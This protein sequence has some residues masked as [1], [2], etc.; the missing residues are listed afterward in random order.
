M[1][2][3]LPW[4]AAGA[5]KAL[6]AGKL[7]SR[8]L[9]EDC[10]GRIAQHD[11]RLNSFVL[12]LEAS[13]RRAAQAA[14]RLRKAGRVRGSLHGIPF[15]LKDMFETAGVRTTAHSKLLI[16]HV[17]SRDSTVAAKLKAAG[18]ILLGKL[19]T[20]EFASGGP[21]WDLPFPPAR[22]PWNTARFTGGS[23]SGSGA[24]VA[25][26]LVP[27]AMGTDTSGSIRGPA[28][29][30]GI[31]GFKPTYGLVSRAG[32]IPMATTLDHCGPMAW[33][34]EDCALLL[35]CVAGH[36]P[37][38]PSSARTRTRRFSRAING[39]I[40]G[41]RIGVVRHMYERDIN[42][43]PQCADAIAQALK[44]LRGLG[45]KLVTV[46]LPPLADWDACCRLLLYPE[47]FAIHE[48]DLTERP[49]QYAAITRAR[50]MTGQGIRA[51]DYIQALRWRR[52]L[53]AEYARVLAS[54]DTLV[55]ACT[56][57]PAPPIEQAG[58]PPYFR[59]NPSLVVAPFSVTG[60]PAL[61]VCAGFSADG[62]PLSL[63]FAGRPFD[64][65]AVLRL[66]HAY[67]TATPWRDRRPEM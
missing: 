62:L 29:F 35:E 47:A 17:P 42:C 53:C 5:R 22:N 23:S 19:A 56:P 33:T 50:L 14:D 58:R 30:C 21:A 64:D 31:A 15:A 39:G 51:S 44:V 54:V 26:G 55:T 2:A 4:T 28:S 38:D 67:E 6:D 66:G 1:T 3:A 46:T 27:L 41:M 52:R 37:L 9:V 48:Q 57:G 13:A 36:D 49:E 18:A 43:D 25:G 61:S 16:D 20:H 32:V 11:H 34:V 65:A 12:V 8:D 45:A 60:A 63:Q 59:P 40:E 7:S 24:A 10:L